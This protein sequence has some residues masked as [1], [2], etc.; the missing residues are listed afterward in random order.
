MV[1]AQTPMFRDPQLP[2]EKRV[3]DL[4]SLLTTEEKINLLCADAYAIVRLGI[5][6]YHWWNESLHGVARA[7]KA[8]VFPKPINLGSTWDPD[9]ILRVATAISDEG[10]AKYHQVLREKGFSE[11]YEGITFFSPTVNIA[12]DPRWGRTSECYSEDPL[13]NSRSGTSFVLGLQGNDPKYLKTVAT[14]KH[15]VANNEEDRRHFGSAEVNMKSLREYYFPAYRDAVV[16]GKATSIMG[17]YNSLNGV[18]CCASHFLLTEVLRKEWGFDGVVMSDGS[19]IDK[20]FT[21]HKF[22]ES[23]EEGA[24][25]ALLAGCDMSLR[26]EYREGLKLALEKELIEEE[27]LN[28]ALRRV[29]NLRFRLGMFDPPELV[30]YAQ[31]PYSV[32][33]SEQHRQL[34]LEAAEKSIILLKNQD[35]L[36]LNKEKVRKVALIGKEAK[37][38]YYGDYSGKSDH[39]VSVFDGL[40][41]QLPEQVELLY[42]SEKESMKT[43]AMNYF[44]REA[45]QVY[46]GL[47]GLMIEYFDNTELSGEPALEKPDIQVNHRFNKPPSELSN[48]EL[49]SIRLSGF[50]VPPV[51]GNYQL[52]LQADGP[53]RL[54]IGE[55]PVVN[56]WQ[57]G[58]QKV[59]E[60]DLNLMAGER[61]TFRLEYQAK[62]NDLINLAWEIPAT[63]GEH[64]IESVASEADVALVFI[65]D[66]GGAEGKDRQSLDL[67]PEQ[68]E[69]L[70]QVHSLNPNTIA[71][72]SA[73]TPLII[74]WP[75]QNLPGIIYCWIPGQAEGSA[76]ANILTGKTNPSAKTPVTFY[77]YIDQLPLMDSYNVDQGRSY[78]YFDGD[79]LYPFG[80]GLSYTDYSYKNLK[81]RKHSPGNPYLKVTLEVSNT[82]QVPGEEIIQ[83][84]LQDPAGLEG[85]PEKRLVEFRRVPLVAG[86]TRTVEFKIGADQLKRWTDNRWQI[87]PGEY[88]ILMGASAEDVRL[89]GKARINSAVIPAP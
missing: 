56:Q 8:T 82:G 27:N 83:C 66:D 24:A 29:L 48:P 20:I 21:H 54:F 9:L 49:F 57:Q 59:F 77:A 85:L 89:E 64:S 81:I 26:N 23:K 88:R 53:V 10:R 62:R 43:I 12:R 79:V 84:Y 87:R 31:I 2:L 38:V 37:K 75:K 5:P 71:I 33:E 41:A 18:P 68:L 39:G 1:A 74:N 70:K 15:F 73:S 80:F 60:Q 61:Y 52:R 36:P 11:I 28:H 40:L 6:A 32:V 47:N 30:P 44:E 76:L 3:S 50:L 19:A 4:V 67:Q 65:R 69:L 14:P 16:Q 58:D 86:E 72:I 25:M 46:E 63:G 22:A 78:Q 13:L 51:S 45:S 7:G 42:A 17:A 34:A 35:I 55:E